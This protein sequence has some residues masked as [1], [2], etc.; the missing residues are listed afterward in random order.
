[1]N[2]LGK[3]DG[4]L[5]GDYLVFETNGWAADWIRIGSALAGNW[6]RE[7]H[8]A[9]YVGN[10]MIVEAQPRG[11]VL[12]PLSNYPEDTYSWS[13][14]ELTEG[15]R[16]SIVGVRGTVRQPGSGALGMIGTPYNWWSIAAFGLAAVGIRVGFIEDRAKS[17]ADLVC[18]QLV[19]WAYSDVGIRLGDMDPWHITPGILADLI[20][21]DHYLR[22]IK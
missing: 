14:M 6:S 9:I 11:A 17:R 8:A 10:G 21:T 15:E 20:E 1:M 3:D 2:P 18:S 22:R 16:R 13:R 4:P 19:G 5:L 7:N 12:S